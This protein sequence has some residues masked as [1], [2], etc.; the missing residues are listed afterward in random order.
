[1]RGLPQIPKEWGGGHT[2]GRRCPIPV[3]W[4]VAQRLSINAGRKPS[5]RAW[6]MFTPRM[7]SIGLVLRKLTHS[8]PR[9][10][11]NVRTFCTTWT[12][13]RPGPLGQFV[14]RAASGALRGALKTNQNRAGAIT[15]PKRAFGTLIRH[16]R[17][18]QLCV[19]C[20]TRRV[21][22]LSRG[23]EESNYFPANA[24]RAAGGVESS[25]AIRCARDP[26]ATLP[27]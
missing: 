22:H 25:D 2:K 21:A 18:P 8:V 4:E 3:L 14:L 24:F 27:E 16:Y 9:R 17:K 19:R 7:Q 13:P 10:Y 6:S 15:R 1:M 5:R 11:R 23:T 20:A 12:V 26:S